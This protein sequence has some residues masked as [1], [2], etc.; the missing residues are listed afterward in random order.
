MRVGIL[1]VLLSGQA[2][3]TAA[4]GSDAAAGLADL[5]VTSVALLRNQ[6]TVGFV[7]EGWAFDPDRSAD[8]AVA[9]VG[10][11]HS[12]ASALLPVMHMGVTAS[13]WKG[14]RR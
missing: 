3:A 7:L 11:D 14:V 1:V 13:A 9:L 4:L 10:K 6:D 12:G 5:G 8:A 2:N